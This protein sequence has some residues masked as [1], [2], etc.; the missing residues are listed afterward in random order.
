[1]PV[2]NYTRMRKNNT[3][4]G[5]QNDIFKPFA[6]LKM[7]FVLS[8][9]LFPLADSGYHRDVRDRVGAVQSHDQVSAALCCGSGHRRLLV[10]QRRCQLL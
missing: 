4:N 8:S 7:A 6:V 5:W 2:L 3:V 1:M 9:S 10:R